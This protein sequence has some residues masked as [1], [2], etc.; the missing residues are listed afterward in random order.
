MTSTS[1][2][3]PNLFIWIGDT[4]TISEDFW[5]FPFFQFYR[6][7]MSKFLHFLQ[8]CKKFEILDCY[9]IEKEFKNPN[10]MFF[11]PLEIYLYNQFWLNLT[12]SFVQ[13]SRFMLKKLAFF[14]KGQF[15]PY[16][17]I[18]YTCKTKSIGIERH[19]DLFWK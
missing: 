3:K 10:I 18:L 5:N 15:S 17:L 1:Q 12:C 16:F 7:L 11:Y 2:T 6:T 4:K 19:M 8:F 13:V 9:K 14:C